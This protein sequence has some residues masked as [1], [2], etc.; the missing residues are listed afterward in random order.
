MKTAPHTPPG[1]EVT[2]RSAGPAVPT[3][4]PD[5][6]RSPMLSPHGTLKDASPRPVDMATAPD[7]F[8]MLLTEIT[9]HTRRSYR[10]TRLPTLLTKADLRLLVRLSRMEGCT[11]SDLSTALDVERATVSRQIIT[12]EARQLVVRRPHPTDRRSVTLHLGPQAQFHV[13]KS[14]NALGARSTR[15][16]RRLSAGEQAQLLRLLR[17]V[18]STVAG[19]AG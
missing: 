9:N 3:S 5:I 18:L 19:D 10:E 16:L 4:C 7:D 2:P 13:A 8:T 17:V 15:A 11:Q 6:A 1:I 14:R 12:L